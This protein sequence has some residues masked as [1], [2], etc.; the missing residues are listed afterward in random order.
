M[1]DHHFNYNDLTI[2]DH[3]FKADALAYS[4]IFLGRVDRYEERVYKMG[5]Y[6]VESFRYFK[7]LSLEQLLFFDFNLNVFSIPVDYMDLI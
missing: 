5:S 3:Y 7:G 2:C 4:T 1:F 6:L